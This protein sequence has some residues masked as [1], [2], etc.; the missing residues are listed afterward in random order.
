[1]R[2]KHNF[3]LFAYLSLVLLGL[4]CKKWIEVTPKTQ[5]ES[6]QFFKDRMGYV[7]ALNGAYIKMV[8][9]QLYGREMTFGSVDIL[10]RI[11][12]IAAG[13]VGD[14]N[15]ND[16]YNG[17]YLNAAPY[18]TITSIWN[19]SFNIIANLNNLLANIDQ[20]DRSIFQPNEYEKIKGEALGLR[21]YLHFD[22]LRLFTKSYRDGAGNSAG[23]PYVINYAPTITPK[24]TVKDVIEKIINDLKAAESLLKIDESESDIQPRQ[25]RFNYYAVKGTLARVYLWKLDEINALAKAD[26]LIAIRATRFPFVS[27]PAVSAAD[28]ARN[29]VFTTEHLFGLT[30]TRL[31][32]NYAGLLDTAR[33]NGTWKMTAPFVNEVYENINTDYRRQFLIRDLV[34]DPQIPDAIKGIWYGKLYQPS[35]S[36]R[37]PLIKIPEMYYI[38]AECTATND[39]QRATGY[40]NLVRAARGLSPL[41]SGLST[42]RV[43][44]EIRKEYRKEMPLEGQMFYF[45]KRLNY[46]TVPGFSGAYPKENYVLPLPQQE[47]DFGS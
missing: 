31:K 23:I 10:G 11:Y 40:L 9:P 41:G 3:F 22:L 35:I 32:D 38:A 16:M 26:E 29:R 5:I 20:S 42:I 27:L 7:E 17:K 28:P 44:D 6:S 46:T 33:N 34:A 4:S 8:S 25:E 15:V 36:N 13:T 47:I 19:N 1:M 39:P 2:I 37:M 18:S 12:P 21:A 30:S 24:G 14:V 45:Y 43:L